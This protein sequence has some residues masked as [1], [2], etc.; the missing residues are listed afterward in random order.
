MNVFNPLTNGLFFTILKLMIRIIQEENIHGNWSQRR[1]FKVKAAKLVTQTVRSTYDTDLIV[2]FESYNNSRRDTYGF[3]SAETC[4]QY[5]L[6]IEIGGEV[7]GYKD[8]IENV[9]KFNAM[10]ENESVKSAIERLP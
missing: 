10:L 3:E 1:Q 4:L 2:H 8:L 9:D 6:L 7:Y 5:R